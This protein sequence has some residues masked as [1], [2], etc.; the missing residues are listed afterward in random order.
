MVA[1]M[2]MRSWLLAALGGEPKRVVPTETLGAGAHWFYPL[3]VNEADALSQIDDVISRLGLAEYRTM[4]YDA[5]VASCYQLLRQAVL[6]APLEITAATD[7]DEAEEIAQFCREELEYLDGQTFESV[8]NDMLEALVFGFACVEKIWRDPY[9]AGHPWAGMQGYRRFYAL[10]QE[11]LAIKATRSGEIESDGVWQAKPDLHYTPGTMSAAHYDRYPR[12]KFVIWAWDRKYGSPYGQSLLRAAY[13]PWLIKKQIAL[14]WARYQ[15][16]YGNPIVDVTTSEADRAAVIAE[17]KKGQLSGILTHGTQT[18][19]SLVSAFGSASNAN[20]EA[21]IGYQDREIG[22]A[23][24]SPSLLMETADSGPAGSSGAQQ[25]S[26]LWFVDSIRRSL[27]CTI[28]SDVLR[29]L[30][31]HNW[32]ANVDV[33]KCGFAENDNGRLAGLLERFL[34]AQEMGLDIG[35]SHVR[36][37]LGIPAPAEGET[38]LRKTGAPLLDPLPPDEDEE[39][40]DVDMNLK[41]KIGSMK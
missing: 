33:P 30:V 37:R 39:E 14:A 10:P 38:V 32:G 27:A 25:D 5:Q 17:I 22:K 12:D 35:E 21:A 3:Y 29:P 34:K 11:T 23:L 31:E 19:I 24:L 15:E 2:G 26:F 16:R 1:V 40:E 9:P 13:R 18:T 36:T 20:F 7:D 6:S 28:R 41:Q 8:M 4:L